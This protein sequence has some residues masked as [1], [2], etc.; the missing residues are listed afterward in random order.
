MRGRCFR[1]GNGP[2]IDGDESKPNDT[3]ILDMIYEILYDIH[4]T[5][6]ILCYHHNYYNL[7][8]M[9]KDNDILG[10]NHPST[11]YVSVPKGARVLPCSQLIKPMTFL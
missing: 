2:L 4:S 8:H 1:S 3:I 6:Y 5:L 9:F 11:S 7:C 10:K